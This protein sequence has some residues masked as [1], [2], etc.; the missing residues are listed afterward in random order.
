MLDK[1]LMNQLLKRG[2]AVGRENDALVKALT[3]IIRQDVGAEI[4]NDFEANVEEVNAQ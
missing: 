1:N 3:T 2:V 4:A